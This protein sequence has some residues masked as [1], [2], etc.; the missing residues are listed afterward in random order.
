[1]LIETRLPR[2]PADEEAIIDAVHAALVEAFRIP[3]TDRELRLVQHAPHR[4]TCPG[5]TARSPELFTLVTIG[6][7][8]GRSVDAKTR[9]VC[10]HRGAAGAAGHPARPLLTGAARRPAGPTGA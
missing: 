3:G 5:P 6:A 9:A 2:P 10:R 8:A 7:F 4:M 1:M